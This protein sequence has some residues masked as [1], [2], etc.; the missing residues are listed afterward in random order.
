MTFAIQCP[1][2]NS[3]LKA[4]AKLVGREL[5]CPK[6]GTRLVVQ[7][8]SDSDLGAVDLGA[9]DL[10]AIDLGLEN[11]PSGTL[12]TSSL[13][14]TSSASN[15]TGKRGVG[16]SRFHPLLMPI[17]AGVGGIVLLVVV[18]GTGVW[19]FVSRG[20][21]VVA[22]NGEPLGT[23]DGGS[24]ANARQQLKTRLLRPGP[25]PQE[26]DDTFASSTTCHCFP[27]NDLLLFGDLRYPQGEA[28]YPAVV[29]CHGGYAA[30]SGDVGDVDVFLNAGFAVF[31]PTFRG[32][33]GNPGNF[34]L[35]LGEAEDA[36]AAMEYL[37]RDPQ[38][39][40][41][42]I[43]IAGHSIG[44]TNA[45][46]AAE[47]SAIPRGAIAV[48]GLLDICRLDSRSIL[49]VFPEIPYDW[50]SATEHR[51]RSPGRFLSDLNCPI[52]LYYGDDELRASLSMAK[53][54]SKQAEEL[55]K[56][57]EYIELDGRDHFTSLAPALQQG[58]A[59][60]KTLMQAERQSPLPKVERG[61]PETLIDEWLGKLPFIDFD[62]YAWTSRATVQSSQ[63]Q[64]CVDPGSPPQFQLVV[65]SDDAL[66]VRETATRNVHRIEGFRPI[67]WNAAPTGYSSVV[68]VS[69][70]A[71]TLALHTEAGL[72]KEHWITLHSAV[73]FGLR[74]VLPGAETFHYLTDERAI[75]SMSSFPGDADQVRA[76]RITSRLAHELQFVDLADM[77]T[78]APIRVRHGGIWGLTPGN[79]Y[80]I[81][82]Q[83]DA[84]TAEALIRADAAAFNGLPQVAELSVYEAATGRQIC[85]VAAAGMTSG[86]ALAC[87]DDGRELS[88]VGERS[89]GVWD[90]ETGEIKIATSLMFDVAHLYQPLQ[91]VNDGNWLVVNGGRMVHRP[92]GYLVGDVAGRVL[93]WQGGQ[94]QMQSG[95]QFADFP[96]ERLHAEAE[97]AADPEINLLAS[98]EVELVI[99]V[100]SHL[101]LEE[102]E[103]D[104]LRQCIAAVLQKRLNLKVVEPS[105]KTRLCMKVDYRERASETA[106]GI[107]EIYVN[108]RK[109]PAQTP[110]IRMIR[111]GSARNVTVSMQLEGPLGSAWKA[112][113]G[114]SETPSYLDMQYPA[115]LQLRLCSLVKAL[116]K[117]EPDL[118]VMVPRDASFPVLPRTI[119][120][121]QTEPLPPETD[122]HVQSTPINLDS[123]VDDVGGLPY[124]RQFLTFS[125]LDKDL[126]SQAFRLHFTSIRDEPRILFRG[127]SGQG[128]MRAL[129]LD[130]PPEPVELTSSAQFVSCRSE[131]FF[132]SL[133]SLDRKKAL[134]IQDLVGARRTTL[135]LPFF[136]HTVGLSPSGELLALSGSQVGVYVY[137]TDELRTAESYEQVRPLQ[138]IEDVAPYRLVF[139]GDDRLLAMCP[140][141]GDVV[142]ANVETGMGCFQCKG[143]DRSN[144]DCALSPDGAYFY[145]LKS[146]HPDKRIYGGADRQQPELAEFDVKE[147]RQTM[148]FPYSGMISLH[149]SPAGKQLGVTL[150]DY[151]VLILDVHGLKNPRTWLISTLVPKLSTNAPSYAD[152]SA[153]GKY[154]AAAIE[155]GTV[156]VWQMTD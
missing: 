89:V 48:G 51:V 155:D 77:R 138:H 70:A 133:V 8:P 61:N 31:V 153:D 152:W 147:R 106:G 94:V 28:P 119:T 68:G 78:S 79:Q 46:L 131:G 85:Q 112:E 103:R 88:V 113:V 102:S 118:P 81:I 76:A 73:D 135:D 52:Q 124:R 143:D 14:A 60:F 83:P 91:V 21:P 7:P 38:I 32:E 145:L 18:I 107:R 44:A 72:P 5:P 2:C 149:M 24:L 54:V 45:M 110:G 64:P 42:N 97:A 125:G 144:V 123:F 84:P 150:A 136:A 148:S 129:R 39:D 99:N 100:D 105:E 126:N 82:S 96:F 53:S 87:S 134:I 104:D 141:Q 25:A 63:W 98:R 101:K 121:P 9:V 111:G 114:G 80:V 13:S 117:L 33:N 59:F 11:S 75:I 92:T 10:G 34:E 1:K 67:L 40:A 49:K 27:S 56:H 50:N 86:I 127:N 19:I 71:K 137:R 93:K 122:L 154:F 4:K 30:G 15:K 3:K 29:Y 35:Y 16:T 37:A 58:V 17:L 12:L 62:S 55:G 36:V 146:V 151:H 90:L 108:M 116:E 109:Q 65:Q 43:F 6:C 115:S 20:E 74:G 95:H 41:N 69:P 26:F 120:L 132:V 128:V 156:T 142:I 140:R 130:S 22:L 23:V 66:D 57:V 139:S 47:L